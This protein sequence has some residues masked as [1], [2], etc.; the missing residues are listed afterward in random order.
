MSLRFFVFCMPLASSLVMHVISAGITNVFT[1]RLSNYVLLIKY[2]R[3]KWII[4]ILIQHCYCAFNVMLLITNYIFVFFLID[5]III[6]FIVI[7]IRKD[8]FL[9]YFNIENKVLDSTIFFLWTSWRLAS[10]KKMCTIKTSEECIARAAAL[11]LTLRI[12]LRMKWSN[13]SYV[14]TGTTLGWV[15]ATLE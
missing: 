2:S 15:S 1:I 14:K 9:L 10:M 5:W 13:V 12:L 3:P 11:I 6:L 4:I 8:I 7:F